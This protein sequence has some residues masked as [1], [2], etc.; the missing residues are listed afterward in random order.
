MRRIQ[1]TGITVMLVVGL[2]A[3]SGVALAQSDDELI[4]VEDTEESNENDTL[5]N[6]GYDLI[7]RIFV[8]GLSA[9]DGVYNCTLENGPL[10]ATYGEAGDDDAIPVDELD[11]EAGVFSFPNRPADEVA[12]D[13]EPADAPIEYSGADGE[14]GISGGDVSGPNGQ[15]NHGMFMK[16]FNRLYE[17]TG[18]G[19][20]VSHLAQS[21]LGKGDQQ[22]QAGD[23]GVIDPV[24]AGDSGVIDFTSVETDCERGNKDRDEAGETELAQ[25]GNSNGKPDHA[26]KP[27]QAGKKSSSPGNSGSAPG[28]DK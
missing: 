8:W 7:N 10:T 27:D 14:C 12:D 24:E 15:V 5:F 20:V 16:L 9:L 25:S 22:V 23:D 4:E 2:V 11:D 3:G 1:R 18:R 19:C 21:D 26:G 17:G 28:H 13:L 6:F